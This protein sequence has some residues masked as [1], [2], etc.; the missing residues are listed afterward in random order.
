[1]AR[2]SSESSTKSPSSKSNNNSNNNNNNV[3]FAHVDISAGPKGKQLG[4]LLNVEKVPSVLIFQNGK[5]VEMDG[6]EEGEESSIVVERG[7]LNRLEKVEM[8]WIEES[9][10]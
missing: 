2:K 9:V 1:M 5:Q 10:I 7:N 6:G 4:K 3:L 8:H